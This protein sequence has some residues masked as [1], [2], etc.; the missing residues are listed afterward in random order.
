MP[1]QSK[2]RKLKND[3]V[4]E[5]STLVPT[6]PYS[7]NKRQYETLSTINEINNVSSNDSKRLKILPIFKNLLGRVPK[8]LNEVVSQTEINQFVPKIPQAY[9]DKRRRDMLEAMDDD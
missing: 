5:D 6:E 9:V 2:P 3:L 8:P 7:N 4:I 1:K